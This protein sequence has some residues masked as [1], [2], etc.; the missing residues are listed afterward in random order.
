MPQ[1]P[2]H[3]D[4]IVVGSGFAGIAMGIAL[5]AAGRDFAI[6]EKADEIGGTWRDNR[7]PGCECD[8]AA[9]LYSFSFEQNARW[10]HTY[11]AGGEIQDYLL[12]CVE[13]YGLR[14]HLQLD[15]T[16]QQA[17]YDEPT[18]RWTL[19]V[20][21]RSGQLRE[22]TTTALVLGVGA[23]HEPVIPALPGLQTFAG[24][25][26]HTS[27]WDPETTVQ[28][29]RVG[30]IGTGSSGVQIIPLLA[31][32][33]EHLTVFQR[34]PAWVIPRGNKPYTEQQVGR[35]ERRPAAMRA[36]RAVLRAQEDARTAAFITQPR[37]L[38]ALAAVARRHLKTSVADLDLRER[39]TPAYAIGCKR[40]TI[41][42]DY[43]PAL[44]R[45]NVAVVTAAIDRVEPD[46]VVTDDGER[47][48]LDLLVLATGFD[49]IGSYRRFGVVGRRGQVLGDE[50]A[51]D[52]RTHL[53][54]TVPD[55]PNLF[56]LH[57]PNTS[58]DHRSLVPMLEAQA[59][60]VSRLLAERDERGARTVCVRPE[61]VSGFIAELDRR[62]ARLVWESGCASWYLDDRGRNRTLWPSTVR[63]YRKRLR[64]PELADYSFV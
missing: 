24:E 18:G 15:S 49:P 7:Y 58:T 3:H 64:A 34:T 35:F 8:V 22:L 14:Q 63:D 43:Y 51:H 60:L 62:N 42:D 1:T 16:V 54:V 38:T 27:A 23:L 36:H 32:D 28:G 29:R 40:V 56:L 41:S 47:H 59:L 13:K 2:E 30:V 26:R 19:T 33:A 52:A 57:G 17:S 21:S 50:F 46:A 5:R 10:S 20:A 11:A 53:G 9:H 48:P 61:A 4:V 44:T 55:F 37:L 45:D 6:L 39:L 12:H 31:V 25:L